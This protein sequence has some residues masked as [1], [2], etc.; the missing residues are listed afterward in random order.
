MS[1]DP[2]AVLRV[3][4]A[5]PQSQIDRDVA[6]EE[7]DFDKM[8]QEIRTSFAEQQESKDPQATAHYH[9]KLMVRAKVYHSRTEIQEDHKLFF[10]SLVA[11]DI[12]DD[13]V[14]VAYESGRLAELARRMDEIQKR[15]GLQDDEFWPIG[16]G[17]DDYQELSDESEELLDKVRDTVF[18]LLLRRYGLNGIADLYETDRVRFDELRERGRKI[19]MKYSTDQ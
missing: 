6:D 13:A 5:I 3:L 15:E 11:E 18:T 1:D 19:A 12:A 4:F 9:H 14:S 7:R 16:E 17:P 2:A 8:V 10:A